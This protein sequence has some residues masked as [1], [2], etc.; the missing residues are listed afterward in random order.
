M[1][2]PS[3][4]VFEIGIP[5]LDFPGILSVGPS[6]SINAFAEADL[7]IVAD[8][9]LGTSLDLSQ[10]QFAFPAAAGTSN[11]DI[12]PKDSRESHSIC[13]VHFLSSHIFRIALKINVGPS[14]LALTANFT[15]HMI[16]RIDIGVT[17]LGGKGKATVFANVDASAKLD[18]SLNA[19][20][21]GKQAD[22][23]AT[24][25]DVGG[26]VGMKLG[27]LSK[28]GAEAALRTSAATMSYIFPD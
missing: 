7:D 17:I 4:K 5:G 11:A 13:P 12:K 10:M 3:I 26:T 16:P 8:L 20:S 14:D 22:G 19:R 6:F 25:T 15:A 27:V 23:S 18:L 24:K 21:T 1:T 28:V 2:T 9:S